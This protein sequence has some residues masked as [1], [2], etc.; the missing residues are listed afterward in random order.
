[1]GREGGQ[2]TFNLGKKVVGGEEGSINS[3][4]GKDLR[5]HCK[6]YF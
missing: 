6:D 4:L 1:M 2:S 3:Q 5:R